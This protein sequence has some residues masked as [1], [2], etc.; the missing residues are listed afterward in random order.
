M[1]S[2]AGFQLA[3]GRIPGELIA[4]SVATADSSNFTTT[5]V[6]VM[7]V[8]APLVTGRTYS[9]WAGPTFHSTVDGDVVFAQLR[10]DDV[11]GNGLDR[12]DDYIRVTTSTIDRTLLFSMFTA[13]ATGNKT[14]VVTGDRV[15]GSGNCRLEASTNRPAYMLV[16]YES[17]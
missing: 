2:S 8:T 16:R 14:F 15:I 4:S 11:S 10:E 5:E 9:I 3:A 13:T 6:V 17:G 12:T 1:A 7:T